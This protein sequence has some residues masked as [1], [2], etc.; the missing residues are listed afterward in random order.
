MYTVHIYNVHVHA[1]TVRVN[2]KNHIHFDSIVDV[3]TLACSV[4]A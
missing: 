4:D 1:F 2:F 3:G